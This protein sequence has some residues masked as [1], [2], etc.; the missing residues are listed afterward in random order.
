LRFIIT[1]VL[2]ALLTGCASPPITPLWATGPNKCTV[3]LGGGGTVFPDNSLNERWFQ[4]NSA[5]SGYLA[6]TLAANGYHIE[7]LI[8][9]I[10]ENGARLKALSAEMN[11]TGCNKV[12]QV[13]HSLTGTGEYVDS[14]VFEV[15]VLGV[16]PSP[17]SGKLAFTGEFEKSYKFPLVKEVI[18]TLPL[19]GLAT[20]M[21]TEVENSG[22]LTK[23]T[24]ATQ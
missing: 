1:F 8:V 6:D 3:L 4:I 24:G 7:R 21:A 18:E 23:H 14:F 15:S 12:V 13:S 17:N 9:D 20:Q 19:N 2:V 16:S 10:R 11:R 22:R 5:V